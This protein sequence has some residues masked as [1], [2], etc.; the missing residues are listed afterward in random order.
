MSSD[1]D[2]SPRPI[3]QI[4][5]EELLAT[6]VRLGLAPDTSAS[7]HVPVP[8]VDSMMRA[9]A[10]ATYAGVGERLMADHQQQ[11]RQLVGDALERTRDAAGQWLEPEDRLRAAL[12]RLESVKTALPGV[13]SSDVNQ[14]LPLPVL[15]RAAG[16]LAQAAEVLVTAATA[17][18]GPP[19]RAW[20]TPLAVAE[21]LGQRRTTST[22]VESTP[23]SF[24]R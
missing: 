18:L 21:P 20:R 23:W 19:P 14:D 11:Q 9:M 24:A 12:N 15:L 5:T 8:S 17:E 6:L 7:P 13:L 3:D 2:F 22:C 10:G 1:A 4:D 16:E